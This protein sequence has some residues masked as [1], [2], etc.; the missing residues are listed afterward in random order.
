MALTPSS[1][2]QLASRVA[3]PNKACALALLLPPGS[4]AGRAG[5]GCW[6]RCGSGLCWE[7]KLNCHS[8]T[9]VCEA[10]RGEARGRALAGL[11]GHKE[12][13][14]LLAMETGA[15]VCAALLTAPL[16][17]AR[18]MQSRVASGRSRCCWDQPNIVMF[19]CG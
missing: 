8:L 5:A 12:K 6:G 11:L 1:C 3:E 15:C 7:G 16:P 13:K 2:S 18:I 10:R 14:L 9:R 19:R 17:P 4:G